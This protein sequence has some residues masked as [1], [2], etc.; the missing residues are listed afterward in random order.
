M[1][2][3]PEDYLTI[4]NPFCSYFSNKRAPFVKSFFI[5]LVNTVIS[6]DTV[7][8]GIPYFS[9]ATAWDSDVKLIKSI[10]PVLCC[11]IEYRPPTQENVKELING[12][13]TSI[14]LIKDQFV[15]DYKHD[16][17]DEKLT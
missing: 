11:L 2:F 7:G 6:Y 5:S 10:L 13:F 14:K 8:R 12:G 17:P 1:Y 16:N 4:L 9:A 15:L 3:K